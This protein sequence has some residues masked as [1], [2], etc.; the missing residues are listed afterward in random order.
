M[1]HRHAQRVIESCFVFVSHEVVPQAGRALQK[2]QKG[3]VCVC[4]CVRRRG[5]VC[6]CDA[7]AQKPSTPLTL[8]LSR[9]QSPKKDP[10]LQEWEG[11]WEGQSYGFCVSVI[12]L[13]E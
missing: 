2:L 6:R 12:D 10:N 5:C 4:V 8:T 11:E 1:C 13:Q 7:Q 3:G 9:S